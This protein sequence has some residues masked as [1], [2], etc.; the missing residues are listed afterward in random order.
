MTN[1]Y[2]G[3]VG[4]AWID[5]CLGSPK[6]FTSPFVETRKHAEAVNPN[7]KQAALP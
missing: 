6:Y 2:D 7:E 5:G 4:H 3:N 1:K